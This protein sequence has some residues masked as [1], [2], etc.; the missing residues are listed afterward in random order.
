MVLFL[1]VLGF[2]IFC[3]V[4]SLFDGLKR[5]PFYEWWQSTFGRY[6]QSFYDTHRPAFKECHPTETSLNDIPYGVNIEAFVQWEMNYAKE[7][8]AKKQQWILRQHRKDN[9][10]AWKQ[11]E[12]ESWHPA[13]PRPRRS[14]TV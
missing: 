8:E 11:F 1:G 2:I 9:A 10:E 12:K 14:K 13:P 7:Q 4:S 6:P 3:F 5:S